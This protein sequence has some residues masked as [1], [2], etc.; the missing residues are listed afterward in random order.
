MTE[1]MA[2]DCLKDIFQLLISRIFE[3]KGRSKDQGRYLW[4]FSRITRL[5]MYSKNH[6][7]EEKKRVIVSLASHLGILDDEFDEILVAEKLS[8]LRSQY[9]NLGVRMQIHRYHSITWIY[10]DEAFATL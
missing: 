6:L 10:F 5:N 8:K 4:W 1:Y 3:E 9:N 2:R 7:L